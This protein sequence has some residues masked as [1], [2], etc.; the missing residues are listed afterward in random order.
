MGNAMKAND[1]P[2]QGDTGPTTLS[3]SRWIS[4]LS[5][6]VVSGVMTLITSGVST[7]RNTNWNWVTIR[8]LWMHAY[9]A[10][11]LAGFPVALT[12]PRLVHAFIARL[13]S[14]YR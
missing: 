11:W 5:A 13:W 4:V 14:R 3:A 1:A 6:I 9:V 10:A 8:E 2:V 12:L 7:G